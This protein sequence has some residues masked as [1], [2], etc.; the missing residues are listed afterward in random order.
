MQTYPEIRTRD[1]L[2]VIHTCCL[3]FDL[4]SDDTED[5]YENMLY[6]TYYS[7]IRNI[8]CFIFT[9]RKGVDIFLGIICVS[10]VI[11]SFNFVCFIRVYLLIPNLKIYI[12]STMKN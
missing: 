2:L 5:S 9:V 6:I 11:N 10:L 4:F 12:F 3:K 8:K 1:L 7:I